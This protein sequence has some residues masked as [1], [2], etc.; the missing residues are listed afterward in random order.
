MKTLIIYCVFLIKRIG[1]QFVLLVFLI[2]HCRAL[3]YRYIHY[4]ELQRVTD[5]SYTNLECNL[6]ASKDQ[7]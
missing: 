6:L 3:I 7:D 2:S 5:I 1:V 4:T